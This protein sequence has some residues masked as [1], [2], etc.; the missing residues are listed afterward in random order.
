MSKTIAVVN[1][2]GGVA[3]TTSTI[4]IGAGLVREGF[5]ALLID[6]DSQGDLTAA[7]GWVDHDNFDLT[8][9]SLIKNVI[10]EE[11]LNI[12]ETI[13][14]HPEGLDVIPGNIDLSATD[15][16][17]VTAM[18]RERALKSIIDE[19]SD[20]YDYILIDCPPSL[21]M[22]TIN[23][24]TAAD[25]VIIPV[26]AQALPAKGMTQLLTTISKVKKHLNSNLEIA[27]ILMTMRD[28]RT[29]LSKKTCTNVR[30][31]FGKFI[32]V[33]DSDIPACTKAGEAPEYGKTIYQYDPNGPAA[34][35]Y[36]SVCSEL[37][38]GKEK[39]QD[40]DSLKKYIEQEIQPNNEIER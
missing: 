6:A 15:M 7:L 1:Q 19:V 28:N 18:S 27:G 8:T 32:N 26:Q 40:I 14:K 12:N 38:F 23:A 31:N 4:S 16:Q 39:K 3:K 30:N 11:E 2:K 10:N 29:N 34:T 5:R 37:L 22:I 35:A 9:A 24:L 20:R 17:L 21:G 36:T 13:L 33:F 25:S